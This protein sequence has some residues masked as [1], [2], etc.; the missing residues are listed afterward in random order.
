LSRTTTLENSFGTF[1]HLTPSV[2]WGAPSTALHWNCP[3]RR[4]AAPKAGRIFGGWVNGSCSLL[5]DPVSPTPI[6]TYTRQVGQTL[7]LQSQNPFFLEPQPA[8]QSPQQL[9]QGHGASRGAA[10]R[11]GRANAGP[12]LR[13]RDAR[14]PQPSHTAPGSLLSLYRHTAA[15]P[16]TQ[17]PSIRRRKKRF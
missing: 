3:K 13:A 10:W 7:R 14:D 11:R 2:W 4:G 17:H 12:G 9:S 16:V 6:F 15:S 5:P 1:S 8:S